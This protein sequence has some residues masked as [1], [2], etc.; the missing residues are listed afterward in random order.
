MGVTAM[1]RN[2]CVI[3]GNF[4]DGSGLSDG[5]AGGAA[6]QLG[7]SGRKFADRGHSFP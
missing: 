2:I 7:H 1:K 3:G 5:G 6:R 4:Y